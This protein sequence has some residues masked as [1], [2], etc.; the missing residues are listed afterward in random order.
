[1]SPFFLNR[2]ESVNYKENPYLKKIKMHLSAN[3]VQKSITLE[4]FK[5]Y[6]PRKNCCGVL[7]L[8]A[9]EDGKELNILKEYICALKDGLMLIQGTTPIN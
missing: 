2:S 7:F 3:Q 5:S 9:D 4:S 8:C 6:K 1:M